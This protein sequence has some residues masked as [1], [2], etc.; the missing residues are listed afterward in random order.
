[1]G[2]RYLDEQPTGRIRYLDSAQPSKR[3]SDEEM[4]KQSFAKAH[5]VIA[6]AEKFANFMI[7]PIYKS[8]G[9]TGGRTLT[10][11]SQQTPIPTKMTGNPMQDIPSAIGMGVKGLGRDIAATGVDMISSP[12]SVLGGVAKLGQKAISPISKIMKYSKPNVQR[13]LVSEARK[14][15]PDYKYKLYQQYGDDYDRIITKSDKR[16]DLTNS[17]SEWVQDHGQDAIN[18]QEFKQLLK[19]GDATANKVYKIMDAV[20]DPKK[21]EKLS[22]ELQNATPKEADQFRKYIENLPGIRSKLKLAR[23]KGTGMVDFTNS[24]RVLLDLAN[25]IKG[26]ILESNPLLGNVNDAY[27][28]G[29]EN[30][31]FARKYIYGPDSQKTLENLKAFNS[32]GI[33]PKE[34][35]RIIFSKGTLKKVQEFSDADK[36]STLLKEVAK[37]GGIAGGGYLGGKAIESSFGK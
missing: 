21:L 14:A 35:A 31:N 22:M 4:T 8:A 3:I 11:V 26:T 32:L 23:N 19:S 6:G 27:R 10:E 20:T 28:M 12:I 33:Y 13:D 15:L 18:N 34:A 36:L 1:M 24:E 5:P 37:Y 2:I 16:I 25:N 30:I 29:K 17:I 7:D 9:L